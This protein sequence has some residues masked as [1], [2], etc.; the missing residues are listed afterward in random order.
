M[1][2]FK[3]TTRPNELFSGEINQFWEYL[4]EEIMIYQQSC[5]LDTVKHI[6]CALVVKIK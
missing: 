5:L 3:I 6:A 2:T 4:D 1:S